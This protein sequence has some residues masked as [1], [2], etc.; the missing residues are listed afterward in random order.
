MNEHPGYEGTC[1][2][3]CGFEAV[4]L[5]AGYGRS[6]RDYY[7]VHEQPGQLYLHALK[8]VDR[9]RLAPA[10]FPVSLAVHE[11]ARAPIRPRPYC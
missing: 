10:R 6:S 9:Q 5:T 1:Y 4:G 3:A 8:P 7:I 11:L 2:K